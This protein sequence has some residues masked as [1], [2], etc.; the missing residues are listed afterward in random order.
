MVQQKSSNENDACEQL[1]NCVSSESKA[2]QKQNCQTMR[3]VYN[4]QH[5]ER[6]DQCSS[7]V[8]SADYLC[9]DGEIN[10]LN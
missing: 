1:W 6:N 5:F 3:F 8:N 10:T 7:T 2:K 4:V 9:G